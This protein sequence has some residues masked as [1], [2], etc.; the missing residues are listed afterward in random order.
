MSTAYFIILISDYY[1]VSNAESPSIVS[2]LFAIFVLVLLIFDIIFSL[3]S[4]FNY[5]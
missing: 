3:F 4:L 1:D 2:A 5:T